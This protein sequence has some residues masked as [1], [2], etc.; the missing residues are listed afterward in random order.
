A[1]YTGSQAPEV[2]YCL[3]QEEV[4]PDDIKG[5]GQ[6][7]L[8]GY[9][10]Q[11]NTNNEL[12]CSSMAINAGKPDT[13]GMNIPLVDFMGN[14]RIFGDTIDMGAIEY[15]DTRRL[16]LINPNG[17]DSLFAGTNYTIN[18]EGNI[19]TVN[20]E[21]SLDN[22]GTWTTIAN[23][24]INSNDYNWQV[25]DVFSYQGRVKITSATD[26]EIFDISDQPFIIFKNE[27][28]THLI[29][30]WNF[31]NYSAQDLVSGNDGIMDGAFFGN[32]FK[33]NSFILEETGYLYT[34]NRITPP[35][36]FSIALWFK[37]DDI[38]K[39]KIIEFCSE[40][41]NTS[42]LSYDR[43]IYFDDDGI[44]YFGVNIDE[45][46]TVQSLV[47][48]ND[49]QWHF[50]VVT[51]SSSGLAMFI[52]G[53]KVDEF[54]E[55]VT[56]STFLG[57]WKLGYGYLSGW[58]GATAGGV[59]NYE[60]E[61][62]E[63]K[64]Y[65]IALSEEQVRNMG[66]LLCPK[67]NFKLVPEDTDP[68]PDSL[69]V[70][71][72]SGFDIEINS[73]QSSNPDIEVGLPGVL[74]LNQGDQAVLPVNLA[75]S[76]G[77]DSS[78]LR[79]DYIYNS[80]SGFD[81]G[82]TYIIQFVDD[83]S[84]LAVYA[85]RALLYYD[86]CYAANPNSVAT[87]NNLGVLYR[88]AEDPDRALQILSY[89]FEKAQDKKTGYT[90]IKMNVGVVQ[91]DL[92][93]SQE[94]YDYYSGAFSDIED[95]SLT[96][97]IAPQI[98]YNQA[99][100]H[101]V[102]DSTDN[103]RVKAWA[104]INHEK[105]NDFLIAKA[106]VLLGVVEAAEDTALAIS[107]FGESIQRDPGGPIG[108]MAQY[109]IDFLRNTLPEDVYE[110]EFVSICEGENYEGWTEPGEYVRILDAANGADSIVTTYLT[111][112]PVYDVTED[113]TICANENYNGWNST[114]QY[115]RTLE[116]IN[117]CDSVVTTNLTVNLLAIETEYI[118][119]CEED[120]YNGW[121]NSGEYQRI[122]DAQNGCDS[123]VT[124][125]L[126]VHPVYNIS[127][128]VT[129]CEGEEYNGWNESG[130][131]TRI[132]ETVNGCDS[133]VTTNLT[134]ND[135]FQITEYIEICEGDEYFG[136]TKSGE[137]ERNLE[138]Q[139]GC[140]STIT[141]ILT[142]HPSYNITEDITICD[143]AIYQGWTETGQYVRNLVSIYG[144]DSIVT[145]NLLVSDAYEV[146]EDIDICDGENYL[147]WDETGEYQRTMEA[148]N[149]CDSIITTILTVNPVY[150]ITENITI[151]YGETY[152][153]WDETG[154][155]T[156]TLSSVNGCDSTVITNLVVRNIIETTENIDI[157]EG[158][159]YKGWTESGEYQRILQAKNGCDSTVITILTVNPV[160]NITEDIT[161]CEG[162]TYN[163]WTEA[164]QYTRSLVSV[165]GCDSIVITNLFVGDAYEVT[166]YVEICHGNDYNGWDE[167]GEYQRTLQAQSGC[168]SIITTVLTIL[169]TIEYTEEIYICEGESYKGWT[170]NG[171]YTRE[172]TSENGCD[173]VV[174]TYLF[175]RPVFNSTDYI[176]ICEGDS[177]SGWMESGTYTET[178]ES[179]SGCDSIITTVLT[180]NET[181]TTSINITVCNGEDYNGWTTSGNYTLDL[182]SAEG[183]DST[184]NI[185]LTVLAEIR[186]TEDVYICEGESYQ[187]W[188]TTGI[189]TRGLTSF[190]GCDST[191][192]TLLVVNPKP[193]QPYIVQ[194]A[195]TLTSTL[196]AGYFWYL[197]EM[198]I[199]GADSRKLIIDVSGNYQV[200][201]TNDKGCVSDLSEPLYAVSTST[202]DPE[203]FKNLKVYPNPTSG[204]VVINGLNPLSEAQVRIIDNSGKVIFTGLANG[205]LFEIDLAGFASGIYHLNI[206]QE[207]KYYNY[208][209]IKK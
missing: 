1:T 177:Y 167:S 120:S 88:L 77:M 164:G 30:Y 104:T 89:A 139:N 141:A 4:M 133:I 197:D 98:Y 108:E 127:E 82:N 14:P 44:L 60:G 49:D 52:D 100:E 76:P 101:F 166:E 19:N 13:T 174:T 90:G 113:I 92:E 63:V 57:Y 73:I 78:A 105:S 74:N 121:T 179:V 50:A 54:V 159:S 25:P 134:V 28:E 27:T 118:E 7:C 194:D 149:G 143:G 15:Q 23:N 61:L 70:I 196:A 20:L 53:I 130:Q 205:S 145:T 2:S 126:T 168:D 154:Q 102:N 150:N 71:N 16:R 99:W 132:L 190:Q 207:G 22:G 65:D 157:C 136:W 36:E 39:G 3:I 172:L 97:V 128:D 155:Y 138:T 96:S 115:S 148:V 79:M 152:L 32:G 191:V 175:V 173:S 200:A 91:S 93:D 125:F 158:D 124:T 146:T 34:K 119:I 186:T 5:G 195:D 162:G 180:V 48:I 169:P 95:D 45:K 170:V 8:F 192:T 176:S 75:Y 83:D 206:T 129:I 202:N 64:I 178:Y 51:C 18:W 6:G 38:N 24:I 201:V 67:Y 171:K 86:S 29:S 41:K 59:V 106:Y 84:E 160:Y 142:V 110:E 163:G 156:R 198:L 33:Q 87:M 203:T 42:S 114:G 183:C 135:T 165:N 199:E 147:G 161:I 140:D 47:P 112:N 58:A 144:C 12:L 31:D 72:K 35:Q 189:Y 193:S 80:T 204:K 69:M 151:C 66:V 153:S 208:Q 11:L 116:T 26:P 68:E 109:N 184:V 111:V 131:Y 85:N 103:V 56:A 21:Y 107:Y 187:G 9:D 137:Y 10:P 43:H 209:I 117:G 122:L 40:Q 188:T 185:H 62:D 182:V 55:P 123:I 81:L 181:Y 37:T 46:Y 17:N 94:A